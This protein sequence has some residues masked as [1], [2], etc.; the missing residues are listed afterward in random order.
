MIQKHQ[1]RGGWHVADRE[2]PAGTCP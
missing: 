1:Q 2:W